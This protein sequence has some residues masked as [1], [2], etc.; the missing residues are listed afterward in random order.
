VYV[1]RVKIAF[2][3]D[4]IW[5][6][7]FWYVISYCFQ[8]FNTRVRTI[9]LLGY[10]VLG[11]IHR[12]WIVFLLGDIFGCSDTQY[13]TN[14][15]AVCQHHPHVSEWLFGSTCDY[16]D[17]C[18][19]LPGHHADMLLFIKHK[20]HHHHRLWGFFVVIAMLYTSINI[21]IARGQY[22]WVLGALVGSSWLGDR[23]GIRPR[24]TT[25]PKPLGIAVNVSGWLGYGPKCC[26]SK[27]LWAVL[28]GCSG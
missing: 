20:Y 14:Q 25:D 17:S 21:G 11:N 9:Q 22:Y 12:Y 26:V 27:E 28:W 5:Y 6:D 4:I 10:W 7:V 19:H 24:K 8:C 15:T 2:L 3:H 23:K 18:N 16:S 1:Y 13:N